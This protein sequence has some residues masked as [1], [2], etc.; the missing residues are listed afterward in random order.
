M[1]GLQPTPFAVHP[2]QRRD[3]VLSRDLGVF[4]WAQ[5]QAAYPNGGAALAALPAGAT[6]YVSDFSHQW[7]PSVDKTYWLPIGGRAPLYRRSAL[8]SSFVARLTGTGAAQA[9]QLPEVTKIPAGLLRVGSRLGVSGRIRRTA[10]TTT[11]AAQ[12]SVRL[13]TAGTTA[14]A[15]ISAHNI[16]GALNAFWDI[17]DA[18]TVLDSNNIGREY[19]SGRMNQSVDPI[20][21]T[22]VLDLIT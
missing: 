21:T 6:A 2:A 17:Y 11:A 1:Y 15:L 20:A 7:T 10:W 4:T 22:S 12:V 5:L 16:T 3:E 19:Y 13:G 8:Y 14:D 18:I 9:F